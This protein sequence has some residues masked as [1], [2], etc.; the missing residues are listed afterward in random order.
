MTRLIGAIVIG[1]ACCC[2]MLAAPRTL[3]IYFI[4]VEGGAAT[5]IVTPA[6][7]SL[8][9]DAG[10]PGDRDAGRIA[11]VATTVAGLK[12]IDHCVVTHWHRDHVGGVAALAKLIPIMNFYDHGLPGT[13]ASDMQAEFIDAYKLTTQGKS[14]TLKP[15]DEIRLQESLKASLPVHV[16]IVASGGV[17]LGEHSSAPQIRPC[18]DDFQ[19]KPEDT[20]DNANSVGMV[21]TFGRFKFFD[22]SDLTWNI[23]NRLACPKN[24]VGP[25]DVYQ[26]DHHGVDIS[27]NP[28]LVRALDARVAI[29]DSGPRKGAEPGTFAT[30][31]KL[32]GIDAIYQL[33]RNLRTTDRD[34]T[35]LAYIANEEEDCQG[36]FIQLSVEPDG[37]SY[38]VVIPAKQ[39]SRRFQTR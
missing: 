31:S 39:F 35:M 27:N 3:D 16:R 10:F 5:L 23:E 32:A 22:G 33:H 13:L 37:R 29:I 36:N 4:D 38:K 12:Q 20:S 9:I 28:V 2:G 18:G 34:N 21:M 1:L 19:A 30:L 15:G 25:V 14:V 8:L 6:G 11:H 24:I 17:V 26:V 7:Q